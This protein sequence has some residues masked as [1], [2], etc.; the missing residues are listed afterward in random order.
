M[1]VKGP[2]H[3]PDQDRVKQLVQAILEKSRRKVAEWQIEMLEYDFYSST[4]GIRLTLDGNSAVA[5]IPSEWIDHADSGDLH[6]RRKI[7]RAMREAV[8][9]FYELEDE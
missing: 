2:I 5:K 9:T 1:E 7:R 6:F 8:E 3:H 4:Y